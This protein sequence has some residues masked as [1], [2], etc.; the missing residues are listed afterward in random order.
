MISL[1]FPDKILWPNGRGHHMAKH[2]AFQKHKQ[3]AYY[4]TLDALPGCFQHKGETVRLRYT[5]TPKTAHP[6]DK[7]NAVAAMKAFQDGIALALKMDDSAFETPEITFAKPE[8]PGRVEVT[9]G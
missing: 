3:W 9:L 7:D 5:V 2:R 4:A 8:K 6:I 1:P